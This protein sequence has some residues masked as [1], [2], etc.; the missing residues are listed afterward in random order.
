MPRVYRNTSQ[1]YR[2]KQ[3]VEIASDD[4]KVCRSSLSV[5]RFHPYAFGRLAGVLLKERLAAHS[6][7]KTLKHKRPVLHDRQYEWSDRYVVSHQIALCQL[8][9]RKKRLRKVRNS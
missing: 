1:L 8:P 3:S 2:V 5:Y 7:G 6:I 4:A 9:A